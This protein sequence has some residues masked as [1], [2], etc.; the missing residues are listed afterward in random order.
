[1]SMKIRICVLFI[2]AVSA[3]G[4]CCAEGSVD[5]YQSIGPAVLQANRML[6]VQYPG[7]LPAGFTENNYKNILQVDYQPM[8][9]RIKPY[10]VQIQKTGSNFLVQVYDCDLLILTDCSLTENRIECWNYK[11]ECNADSVKAHCVNIE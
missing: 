3:F 10:S 5:D 11:A 9:E 4:C 6:L 7:G 1:M 8:Y 2:L